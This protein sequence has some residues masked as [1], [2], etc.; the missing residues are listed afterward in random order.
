MR[1]DTE[2]FSMYLTCQWIGASVIAAAGSWLLGL[3]DAGH[4][5]KIKLP[6]GRFRVQTSPGRRSLGDSADGFILADHAVVAHL[7]D[8]AASRARPGSASPPECASI[9]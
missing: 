2:C 9:G 8:A 5:G 6:I 7:P 4:F 1:R 3:A